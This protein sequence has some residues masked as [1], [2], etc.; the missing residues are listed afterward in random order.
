MAAPIDPY[1]EL[2]SQLEIAVDDAYRLAK[3]WR[4][5]YVSLSVRPES[6]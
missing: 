6:S 4:I 5:T 2:K 1:D 3:P